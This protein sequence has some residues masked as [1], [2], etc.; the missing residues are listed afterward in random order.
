M[1]KEENQAKP[2]LLFFFD[3]LIEEEIKEQWVQQKRK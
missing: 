1:K 3:I 2:F